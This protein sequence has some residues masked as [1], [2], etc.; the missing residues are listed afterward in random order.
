LATPYYQDDF[1]TLY[2][3]DCREI[4]GWLTADVLVTDPPYGVNLGAVGV[5]GTFGKGPGLQRSSYASY[6][7]TYEEYVRV[8]VPTI[9]AGVAAT[10]R[11]GVFVGP[12]ITELP[13]PTV[14]GGIYCPGGNGRHPWGFK[15]FL[16]VFLYGTSPDLEQGR[17][18]RGKSAVMSSAVVQKNGHPCP[19]PIEWMDWLVD[20]TSSTGETV[21]DPFAG[22]GSTLVAAKALSRK[23]IGIELE[24]RYCE[25]AARRLSQD[26]FDFFSESA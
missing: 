3:G 4:T 8:V 21:A 13:K 24:E 23:A 15:L 17:G 1:V 11:A 26:A 18:A 6:E 22:S 7:D 16:P 5:G 10:R 14:I 20:L 9:A 12:H 25:I 19:K 2:H